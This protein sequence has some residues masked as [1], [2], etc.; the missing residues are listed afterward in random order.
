M[1]IYFFCSSF[2]LFLGTSCSPSLVCEKVVPL[3][4]SKSKLHIIFWLS[5]LLDGRKSSHASFLLMHTTDRYE[6]KFLL[7][8]GILPPLQSIL[9][10]W[11]SYLLLELDISGVNVFLSEP[12]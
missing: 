8:L 10:I 5:L 2:F 12:S 6:D 4:V 9:S 7:Y 11:K 3:L 1:Y